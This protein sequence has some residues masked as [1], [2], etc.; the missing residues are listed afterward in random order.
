MTTALH[1]PR[2]GHL[3][4]TSVP[5][6]ERP[7]RCGSFAQSSVCA[8][9]LGVARPDDGFLSDE[10]D[11]GEWPMTVPTRACG[12]ATSWGWALLAGCVVVFTGIGLLVDG[13][14]G[15]A[16][17]FAVVGVFLGIVL[18]CVAF[19]LRVRAVLRG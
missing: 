13:A 3:R 12:G 4:T 8:E 11:L 14:A 17:V 1:R 15:T 9:A 2:S 16:P 19:W 7:S 10:S 5:R 6:S 18:G